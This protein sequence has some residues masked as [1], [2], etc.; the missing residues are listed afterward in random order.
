MKTRRGDI[1]FRIVAILVL[2]L[3]VTYVI[4]IKISTGYYLFVPDVAHPVAPLVKVTGAKSPRGG[5]ELY[6]VDVHEFPASEFDM[7]FRSWLYPHSTKLPA[8]DLLA[9]G[10]NNSQYIQGTFREMAESQK[11]AGAVAERQL[12]LPVVAHD[13]GVL[14][15]N[16]FG[17]IPATA[18]IFPADIIVAANGKPTIHLAA[19]HNAA[20]ELKPGDVIHLTILRGGR[21]VHE[22]VKTIADPQDTKRP[23]IGVQVEQSQK[24]VKLPVRVSI[25]S[26][27]IGGPSAGLAF[28]L[29][30]MRQLGANV[31]H[32]YNVAATG[33]I[34]LDG[35]VGAIGGIEQKTF[36]VRQA[37]AQ[38]FLVPKAGD[39]ARD[40]RKYAG[41]NLKIIAVT[42][43]KQALRA[44][45]ALPKAP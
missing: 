6:F 33:T 17:G 19:L 9:P 35:A 29:E 3:I 5:G 31:T 14:V 25:N 22:N 16:V 26:G 4:L 20:D 1:A 27:G 21:T 42:S 15:D 40:A 13:N 36:G 28:T 43:L 12:G 30:V 10:Q 11:I 34:S 24:I 18:K 45:A 2:A 38:V 23:L 7:L 32:G 39:N 8:K 37:G 44:L 41:P